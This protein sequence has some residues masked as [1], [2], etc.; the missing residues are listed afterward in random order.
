MQKITPNYTSNSTIDFSFEQGLWQE[1]LC[2]VAGVDE[3]GRG[4]WAGP[5]VAA[6]AIFKPHYKADFLSGLNDSKK[7]SAKKRDALYIHIL[8]HCDYAVGMASVEEIDEIN[9]LQA[10]MLAM[11]RAI[12]DLPSKAQYALIDGNKIPDQLNIPAEAIIKGDGRSYSIA[13]ASIVAKVTRDRLMQ[14]LHDEFP[15]YGW[16]SNA[17]YGTKLHQEGLSKHGVTQHHRRSFKPIQ[18]IILETKQN[19]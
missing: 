14:K 19:Y 5:V 6:A 12:N 7:L 8:E 15:H 3:A 10:S 16:N 13:A 18:K 9:I 4:P 17:G 1:D 11:T 2:F